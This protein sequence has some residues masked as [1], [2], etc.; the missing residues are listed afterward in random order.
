MSVDEFDVEE[1]DL[2]RRT[3]V[4]PK[5][6]PELD[7]RPVLTIPDRRPLLMLSIE[8]ILAVDDRPTEVVDIP[9]WGGAVRIRGLSMEEVHGMRKKATVGMVIDEDLLSRLSVL[10]TVVEPKFSEDQLGLLWSKS[11]AAIVRVMGA[12]TR[13]SGLDRLAADR[14]EGSFR[15]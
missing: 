12:V 14:A 9:E 6:E 2:A 1:P 10:A 11:A 3:H 15:P 13:I 5:P 8:D 7:D 4:K